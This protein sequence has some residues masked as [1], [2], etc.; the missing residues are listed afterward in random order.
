MGMLQA[1]AARAQSILPAPAPGQAPV[2]GVNYYGPCLPEKRPILD[3]FA[4]SGFDESW[5]SG[6]DALIRSFTLS[7]ASD[8]GNG[9]IRMAAAPDAA[10]APRDVPGQE[11]SAPQEEGTAGGAPIL[12]PGVLQ[13]GTRMDPVPTQP[14]RQPYASTLHKVVAPTSATGRLNWMSIRTRQAPLN[15]LREE[16]HND[17]A[18]LWEA[19]PKRPVRRDLEEEALRQNTELR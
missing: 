18:G 14:L 10:P 6:D 15:A 12:D 2:C 8:Q 11:D 13:P 5:F 3:P 17:A 1:A 4:R 7:E 19:A 16:S 9:A